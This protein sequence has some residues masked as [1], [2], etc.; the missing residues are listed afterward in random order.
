M[1]L[2]SLASHRRQRQPDTNR[3]D[4]AQWE[5]SFKTNIHPFFYLA[6]YALPHMKRGSTII[7]CSS[8]NPYVGRPDLLD[9]TSTKGAIVA[10]TRA[11]SNQ[12]IGKGIRVNCVC[13]GPST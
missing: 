7:N 8:V 10:F 4:R 5:N 1:S 9:Y 3:T 11:L 12:Q 2:A 6:K 13:P